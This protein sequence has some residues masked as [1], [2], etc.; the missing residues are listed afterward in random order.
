M[1]SAFDLTLHGVRSVV[2]DMR[3]RAP[4]DAVVFVQGNPGPSDDWEGLAPRVAAFARVVAMDMPGF[5]RADRPKAFDFTIVGF[6]RYLGDILD[7]V[8]V[9]RAHLVLHDFGGPWGLA[10]A[11]EQPERVASV[12]LINTGVV[13]G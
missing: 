9:Q 5:G 13:P 7:A 10:W 8:G 12:T 1:L 3:P 2:H 11:A 4:S 6:A